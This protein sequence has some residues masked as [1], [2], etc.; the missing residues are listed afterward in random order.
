MNEELP[1]NI[2][3]LLMM[4]ESHAKMLATAKA[5]RTEHIDADTKDLA[6]ARQQLVAEI[7]KWIKTEKSV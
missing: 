5:F 2:P 3:F 7:L 6:E 4:F 1:G